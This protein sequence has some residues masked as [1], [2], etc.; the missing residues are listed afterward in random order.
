MKD[1]N[2]TERRNGDVVILDLEGQIRIGENTLKLRTTLRDYV[3]QGEKKL[4]VNLDNITHID[5]SG[6]G[7]L[8]AGYVSFEKAG[9]VLK[10][11]KLTEHV[12]EL[13][14]ITKLLTVFETF[15]DE[16]EAVRSFD[17]GSSGQA[18]VA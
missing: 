18:S 13:M 6:L 14:M 4:L 15:S 1:L 10:L 12:S 9:G 8:V 7:D 17:A 2:I 3:D 16:E 5:S 11:L